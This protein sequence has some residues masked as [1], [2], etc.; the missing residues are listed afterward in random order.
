VG[1]LPMGAKTTWTITEPLRKV[2]IILA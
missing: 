2:W 1:L